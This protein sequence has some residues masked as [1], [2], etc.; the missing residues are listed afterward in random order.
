MLKNK[1]GYRIVDK[2]KLY[3]I[4]L[5]YSFFTFPFLFFFSKHFAL[6][7]RGG[8]KCRRVEKIEKLETN[9]KNFALTGRKKAQQTNY[10]KLIVERGRRGI[11]GQSDWMTER[12][13]DNWT[14]VVMQGKGRRAKGNGVASF[15]GGAMSKQM[16]QQAVAARGREREASV[17]FYVAADA[18]PTPACLQLWFVFVVVVAA[19][20]VLV[21]VVVSVCSQQIKRRWLSRSPTHT[22]SLSCTLPLSYSTSLPLSLSSLS[23]CLHRLHRCVRHMLPAVTQRSSAVPLPQR[24]CCL[25]LRVFVYV[26]VCVRVVNGIQHWKLP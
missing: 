6:K 24:C 21:V 1:T 20:L 23:A 3:F 8:K 11:D 26:C 17:L 9:F 5:P 16:L 2:W 4:L 10:R 14:S 22:H 18:T 12:L 15:F 19:L 13:T 25:C 7:V